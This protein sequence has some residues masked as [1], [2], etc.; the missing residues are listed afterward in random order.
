MKLTLRLYSVL[1]AF[2]QWKSDMSRI[3]EILSIA[4]ALYIFTFYIDGDI[5]IVIIAF[6]VIAPLVSLFFAWYGRKR[7][8]VSF[9]CDGYVKKKSKL[10]VTVNVEK[11]GFFPLGIIEITMG[12]SEV[13]GGFEKV[14]K[15]SIISGNKKSFTVEVDAVTG[16]NGEISVLDVKSCGFLGYTGLK[17]L[18]PMPPAKSVG[19]IPEIPEIKTTSKLFRSIADSV[20]TSDEEENS[21]SAQFFSASTVPGYDHR[22][23]EMGDPLKRVNWKLSAKK[24]TMMVRLDEAVSSVQPIIALDLYRKADCDISEAVLR[25]ETLLCSVFGLLSMLIK[26]GIASTFIYRSENGEMVSESVENPEY[27]MQLLLKVLAVKVQTDKRIS[28]DTSSACSCVIAST[29]C[30]A[31]LNSVISVFEDKE[32]INLIGASSQEINGTACR[33]WYLDGDNNFKLV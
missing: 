29:D 11:T 3:F 25:E 22:E 5:G 32:N 28:V 27:P 20:V 13:F 8:K 26:H 17:I 24:G 7:V 21:E 33:M 10:A 6:M 14:C 1:S 23:Y 16:G 31:S 2:L 19:V 30:S 4:L 12:A 18:T 15:L 9:S